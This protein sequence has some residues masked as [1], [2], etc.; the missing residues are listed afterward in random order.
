MLSLPLVIAD[1]S[2]P[3]WLH[4]ENL[5]IVL[6]AN[7]VIWFVDIRALISGKS[8]FSRSAISTWDVLAHIK[9]WE[10]PAERLWTTITIQ[11][12][13]RPGELLFSEKASIFKCD[14]DTHKVRVI[15]LGGLVHCNIKHFIFRKISTVAKVVELCCECDRLLASPP[16]P[17]L[18]EVM[19]SITAGESASANSY[20]K[21]ELNVRRLFRLFQVDFDL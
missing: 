10:V 14:D 11:P 8:F 17:D 7:V 5:H 18:S 2:L 3:L 15:S 1:L 21:S 16:A 19:A 4:S 12:V 13:T 20:L 9:E 6:W